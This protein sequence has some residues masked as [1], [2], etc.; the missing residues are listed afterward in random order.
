[1]DLGLIVIPSQ[2]VDA[3][4]NPGGGG[5]QVPIDDGI[6]LALSLFLRLRSVVAGSDP[7][8][9]QAEG[10]EQGSG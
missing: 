8:L 1:M 4:L 9:T 3:A 2:L 7:G 10:P 5:R 6:V